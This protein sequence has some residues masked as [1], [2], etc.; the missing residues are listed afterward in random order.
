MFP[1]TL[2]LKS[3]IGIPMVLFEYS[4]IIRIPEKQNVRIFD[5]LGHFRIVLSNSLEQLSNSD[6]EQSD[7]GVQTW[8]NTRFSYGSFYVVWNV[9]KTGVPTPLCSITAERIEYS[10]LFEQFGKEPVEYS[11][12]SVKY[13]VTEQ[14]EYAPTNSNTRLARKPSNSNTRSEHSKSI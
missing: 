3:V 13:S 1:K 7:P 9:S 10:V 5:L 11:I 2:H 8:Q 4:N 6:I 14:I 12:C